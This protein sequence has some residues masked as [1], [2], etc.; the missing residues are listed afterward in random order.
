MRATLWFGLALGK[1]W[2]PGWE[3]YLALWVGL[4]LA[5]DLLFGLM[6]W[7]QLRTRF[8]ELALRRF[9]PAPSRFAR[10]FGQEQAGRAGR[11][12]RSRNATGQPDEPQRREERREDKGSRTSALFASLRLR[13]RFGTPRR[14]LALFG[15]LALV[16]IGVGCHCLAITLPS[17]ASH[18]GLLEP[19]QRTG[20][21][22][23]RP[24]RRGVD[25]PRWLAL[26][27]GQGGSSASVPGQRSRNRWEPITIGSKPL[28][29][30]AIWSGC[31][32]TA[33]SGSG[34]IAAGTP[35][36]PLVPA[37]SRHLVDSNH[38]WVGIAASATHS[39]ALRR[40][41]T[42]W[43]WGDNSMGQLG[44]GPGP[45]QTN[46]VQVGTNADWA[47]VCCAWRRHTGAAPGW[48]PLGLGA[49]LCRRDGDRAAMTCTIC[50][51]RPE[52]ASSRIGPASCPGS[53]CRWCGTARASYGSR[54]MRLRTPRLPPLPV[55][56]WSLPTRSPG[57]SPPPGAARRRSTNCA[58]DGTLWEKAQPLGFYSGTRRSGEWRRLGK[59]S[60][61]AGLWGAHGTALGLT[62]R[63]HALDL[64]N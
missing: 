63:W 60:D 10:W 27:L 9:N 49:G 19:K 3:F 59:R 6:A 53:S 41:G 47:A 39:V 40:D 20:S 23:L 4:G 36:S 12:R 21:G 52:S 22:L 45:N 42:L 29:A 11:E 33:V 28:Q 35:A 46:P 50:L 32:G 34:D 31:A 1:E 62:S 8:R 38:V 43:A 54:S 64:G 61:W 30:T 16:V 24:R 57:A 56:G 55:S 44:N 2:S 13:L 48:N 14:R 18:R 17:A 26:A 7:W 37:P 25:S 51:G 15:C 5:A 58:P